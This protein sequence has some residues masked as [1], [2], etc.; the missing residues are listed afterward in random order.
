[1][2]EQAIDRCVEALKRLDMRM[3]QEII[4]FDEEINR[5]RYQIEETC[6]ETIATQHRWPAT[7]GRSSPPCSAPPT[8][9]RM[10]DHAKSIAKLTIEMADE[11]LLKPLVDIPRMA[12][13]AKEMLRQVLEAYVEQDPEKGPWRPW[14]GTMRW[15]RWMSRSTGS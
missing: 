2:V 7:C 15:T 4:A 11:P 9:R 14:P 6:L 10:G 5:M 1:M 8:W 3:A 12:Q 13:I